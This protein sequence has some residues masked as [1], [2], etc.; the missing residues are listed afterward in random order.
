MGFLDRAIKNGI[1]KGVSDAIGK[2]VKQV[3]EPRATEY[4]NNVA[5]QFDEATQQTQEAQQAV[6]STSGMEGAF[7]NLQRSM[8]NY[9][10][11]MS[12][13]VKVCPK[14]ETAT[15]S[16]KTFCPNCGEKLPEETLAEGAV[17]P[18]CGKQNTIGTKFCQD[19]GAKLPF[20]IAED[21]AAAEN[22]AAVLAKW[23]ETMPQY[24][25]WNCGGKDF[26]LEINDEY[27]RFSARMENNSSALNAIDQYRELLLQNG[28]R[29]AGEYPCKEHLYKKIDGVCYHVDTEHCLDGD[30]DFPSF[31]FEAAE[32]TG[33]FDYVKPEP[34]KGFGL[35]DIFKF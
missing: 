17:C 20:A 33:G 14:C 30:D 13:N 2:A 1:S 27:Q 11:E 24:P 12:K 15:T 21:K 7:A 4:A 3:V 23:A 29:Q 26:D 16:D 9:A 22:D 6:K 31:A 28:F 8:E 25:V 34:Q 18:S 10:T 32:P 35:K 19:C 5:K